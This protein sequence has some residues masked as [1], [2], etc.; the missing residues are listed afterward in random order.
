MDRFSTG[1]NRHL[2][3]RAIR[4]ER[5]ANR[6]RIFILVPAARTRRFICV[7]FLRSSRE[8][9]AHRRIA[10]AIGSRDHVEKR[11]L[12]NLYMHTRNFFNVIF[13][14]NYLVLFICKIS[15]GSSKMRDTT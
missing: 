1:E 6:G 14:L 9:T 8:I 3:R 11:R 7:L 15:R 13:F 5:K 2:P 10:R 4:G 12:A